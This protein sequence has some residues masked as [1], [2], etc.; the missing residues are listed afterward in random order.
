M[1]GYLLVSALAVITVLAVL[2][3]VLKINIL[4]VIG[5]GLVL[6]FG[7][8]PLTYHV[9]T[10]I[11]KD[12]ATTFNEY[13]NGFET[14]AVRDDTACYRDGNCR[15]TYDCDPYTVTVTKFR[16]VPDGK[17]GTTQESY[18]DTET[19]YHSC[20]VSKQE[21]DFIVRSTVDDYTVAANVMTG[22]QFRWERSIPGGKVTE[23]P[24]AWTDA[25]N[26]VEAG[27][28]GPVTAVKNYKNYILASQD[29]LFKAYSDKID[30]F[31]AKGLLPA[32]SKGVH[33]LYH[34]NKAYTVGGANVPLFNDYRTDVEYLNGAVGD[35]LHGDLHVVFVPENIEGGKDDYL[36]TLTAYWQ[37]KEHKRDA[38]SKNAIIVVIG[39]NGDGKSVAWARATTGMPLGN[40]AMLTQIGSDLKDKPL[41]ANLIGRP[42]MNLGDGKLVHSSGEL[43][44]ILWGDHAFTRVSMS[45]SEEDDEGSG[46]SYLRDELKPS[47]WEVFWIGFVNVLIAGGLTAGLVMLIVHEV[48]PT[49][50]ARWKGS[51][52]GSNSNRYSFY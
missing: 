47:G 19:R 31:K 9:G 6:V 7:L 25:K 35:D 50:F 38:I 23:A 12:Q 45:G 21:T 2:T 26:R 15:H 42:T 14:E 4:P 29:T 46:F 36:N 43:E 34:A 37:S 22:D 32:P 18:P 52:S 24:V 20:P 44:K 49:R 8:N 48:I 5:L 51:D 30:D 1:I 3:Y 16:S 11:A 41:D 13:W 40:E 17:G 28:P 27:R 39:V 10:E 33:G